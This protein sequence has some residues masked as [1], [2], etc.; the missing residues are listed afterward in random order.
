MKRNLFIFYLLFLV[1]VANSQIITNVNIQSIDCNNDTGYIAI[2]TDLS[3]NFYLWEILDPNLNWIQ[4]NN[5]STDSISF[6]DCGDYRVIV[7]NGVPTDTGYFTISCPMQSIFREHDNPECFGDSTGMLGQSITGGLPFIDSNGFEYYNYYWYQNGVLYDSGSSLIE[8]TVR[9]YNL[10]SGQYYLQFMDSIGCV[11]QDTNSQGVIGPLSISSPSQLVIDSIIIHPVQCKGT[12]TGSFEVWINGGKRFDPDSSQIYNGNEYYHYFLLNNFG[13]TV[14][15]GYATD[16]TNFTTL[17]SSFPVAPEHVLFS[18]L[19][20]G[21]YNLHVIDANNCNFLSTV[22]IMEPDDYVLHV[23]NSPAII[24]EQDSTWLI[25]DSVSGGNTLLDYSWTGTSLDSIYVRSGSY[26]VIINDLIY[27]CKD[28]LEYVLTAPN[29]IYTNLSSTPAFCFGTNTG[30]VLIDSIYGGVSPY[31][32]QWGGGMNPD[33]LYAGTYTVYI[34]DSLGC[35]YLEDVIITEHPDISL[36]PSIYPPSCNG[37]FDASIAID[38][39]GGNPPLSYNWS[40]G[41]GNPD[42]LFSIPSGTYIINITDSLGCSYIDS[43]TV[44]DPDSLIISFSGYTNPLLC[45]GSLTVINS[46]INGGTGNYDLVWDTGNNNDTTYQLVVSAGNH[47]LTVTDQNGCQSSNSLVILQP[48]PLT[49]FGSYIQATCNIGGSAS[50]IYSGG[51]EPVSYLWSN[52]SITSSVSD[53]DGGVHWVIVTD[54]CGDTSSF[55][56]EINEYILEVEAYHVNNPDNFGVVDVIESTVGGT[57]SYQW[58]DY[59]MDL[60][61]GETEFEIFD[62]CE[63]WYYVTVTDSNM[64]EII[65]SIYSTFDLPMGIVDESTTTVYPDADLWGAGPYTYLWDNGDI[66]AHGNVCEGIHR[67]WVTDINGCEMVGEVIVED[68]ELELTPSDI[69]IECDI[70]NVD[71]ELEVEVSGG[72]GDYTYLWNSGE[73]INPINISLYPGI[74]SVEV[75]D[76][77][78]CKKDTVFRI[79]SMTEECIPNVFSPNNDGINDTWNL[80]DAFLYLDTEV[81]VYGRYGQLIFKSLGYE[82]PWDGTNQNGNPVEGGVYFYVI[83]LGDNIEKI[84]GTV[85]IIR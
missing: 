13:D 18:N 16:S 29:T 22:Y 25:I 50:V 48:D 56:F 68:I 82:I 37:Y 10:V 19:S 17:P 27:G 36:N 69:I 7:F 59:N 51:T 80:E 77:N 14:A 1:S 47:K 64:C 23:S 61:V 49:T 41:S 85:S 3:A 32:I 58:Y 24:C 84:K 30:T 63:G 15:Y 75:T 35:Q 57:F 52:G 45:N 40:T 62:L 83:D 34:T 54:S 20:V 39:N 65:D 26:T 78:L 21:N 31:N 11:F 60:I 72:I 81:K 9:E 4:V 53:L 8:D 55:H 43:V 67:V 79:A 70:S 46:N 28:S 42:S 73:T 33:S 12:N 38:I 44:Y 74:Y 66:T 2:E 76:E 71:V 5:V 6:T